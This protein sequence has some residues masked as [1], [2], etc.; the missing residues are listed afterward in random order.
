VDL[1]ISNR[2]LEGSRENLII[3]EIKSSRIIGVYRGF[4]NYRQPGFD[5]L[6]YLF[7]LLENASKTTK[8]LTLVGDFNI[9]P[10]RDANTPQGRYLDSLQIN[11]DLYQ[12]VDF[13]TRSRVVQRHS[14]IVLE[15]STIDLVLTNKKENKE[16]FSETTTSDHRLIC[17]SIANNRHVPETKKQLIRDWTQLIPRSIVRLVSGAP[18]P[19]TLDELSNSFEYL[20][21]KLAPLRVVRTRLPYN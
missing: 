9:Y 7:G 1:E 3:L 20:L 2:S 13:K 6:G 11:N 12:L 15:E 19:S 17:V 10:L 5:S 21:N 8:D 4:K 16:I 18:D 14:G